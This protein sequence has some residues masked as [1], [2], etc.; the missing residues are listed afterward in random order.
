MQFQE[1]RRKKHESTKNE[2][3]KNIKFRND[4]QKLY[5]KRKKEKDNVV[6]SKKVC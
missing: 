1:T 5:R 2:R 3:K 6:I 4:Y